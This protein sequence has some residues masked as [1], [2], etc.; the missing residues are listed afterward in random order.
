MLRARVFS[1]N[2]NRFLVPTLWYNT[3]DP[4]AR[5]PADII[6]ESM[7]WAISI[8]VEVETEWAEYPPHPKGGFMAH[9]KHILLT[10]RKLLHGACMVLIIEGP[11]LTVDDEVQSQAGA[12]EQT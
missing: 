8:G 10:S 5:S 4:D 6:I 7:W 9:H 3:E 1:K 12:G 11:L 2:G